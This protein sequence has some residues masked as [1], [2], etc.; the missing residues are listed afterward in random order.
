VVDIPVSVM[1]SVKKVSIVSYK[2][3]K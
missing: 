2:P 1:N 3:L